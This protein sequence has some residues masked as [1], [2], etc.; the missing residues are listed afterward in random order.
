LIAPGL[1]EGELRRDASALEAADE[2]VPSLPVAAV[3][4]ALE[5]PQ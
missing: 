4:A 1:G 5:L 3:A 2:A